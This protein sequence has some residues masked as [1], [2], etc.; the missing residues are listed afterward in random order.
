MLIT[1]VEHAVVERMLLAED[2]LPDHDDLVIIWNLPS[3]LGWITS[4]TEHMASEDLG[5]TILHHINSLANDLIS[6]TIPRPTSA[7]APGL[8]V[9]TLPPWVEFTLSHI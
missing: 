7:P 5:Y 4:L 3:T 2:R 1:R 8:A 9:L 6:S